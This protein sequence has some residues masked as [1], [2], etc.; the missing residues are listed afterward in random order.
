MSGRYRALGATL[1]YRLVA[2]CRLQQ[3]RHPTVA[4]P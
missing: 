1:D 3:N 4:E 2:I